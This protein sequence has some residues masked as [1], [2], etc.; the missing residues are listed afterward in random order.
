MADKRVSALDVIRK[1]LPKWWKD[2][3]SDNKE[4]VQMA[5]AVRAGVK[6]QWV[7]EKETGMPGIVSGV[8]GLPSILGADGVFLEAGESYDRNLRDMLEAEGLPR[9]G[10]MPGWMRVAL[11]GGEVL[12][13]APMSA[14]AATALVG[15]VGSSLPKLVAKPV[16]LATE[17]FTPW[18]NPH[19]VNYAAGTIIGGSLRQ[20]EGPTWEAAPEMQEYLKSEHAAFDARAAKRA[21]IEGMIADANDK[22]KDRLYTKYFKDAEVTFAEPIQGFARG[23]LNRL[24]A[25]TIPK[26]LQG[27]QVIKEAGGNWIAGGPESATDMLKVAINDYTPGQFGYATEA[28]HPRNI[29]ATA[30][31]KWLDQKLKSYIRNTMATKEDP[32]RLG[33]EKWQTV[34]KPSLVAKQQARIDKARTSQLA[35]QEAHP[36]MTPEQLIESQD[37]IRQLEGAMNLLAR[38]TGLH[39]EPGFVFDYNLP[40][41]VEG[42]TDLSRDW[43]NAAD[44]SIRSR[45]AGALLADPYSFTYMRSSVEANPWLLKI[46]PETPVY[47][48]RSDI[49]E[50]GFDHLMDELANALNPESGLPANLLIDP[51][52]FEK[53]NIADA[54]A[55]VGE[56]NAWRGAQKAIVDKR[57][58]MNAATVMHKEYPDDPK[59]VRWVEIKLPEPVIAD[60]HMLGPVSGYPEL[61]GIVDRTTGQSVSAGATPE[62]ALR[63]YNLTER[64]SLLKDALKYEGEQLAHCVGGYCPDV[65][66]GKSR[67]FSLRDAEGK[68][69]TTI[70]TNPSFLTPEKREAQLGYAVQRNIG[71]GMSEEEALASA[72]KL[73]PEAYQNISQIRG[74]LNLRPAEEVMPYISDFVKSGK[75]GSVEDLGHTDL[76]PGDTVSDIMPSGLTMSPGLRKEAIDRARESGELPDYLTRDEYEKLLNKFG[77]A[78]E[79]AEGGLATAADYDPSIIDAIL[80]RLHISGEVGSFQDEHTRGTQGGGNIKV[81][82]TPNATVG[83]DVYGYDIKTPIGDFKDI[84]LSGVSF[85]H[86]SGP[87]RIKARKST[88]GKDWGLE[89]QYTFANGGLV[90]SGYNDEYVD[91]LANQLMEEVYG[92]R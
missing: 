39:Y 68:P 36:D 11:A 85:E 21:R 42:T 82:V 54:V 18:I 58:A 17:Y 41:Y 87:H 91:T 70:E 90:N 19:P 29:R 56:I 31:N 10:D 40:R 55:R 16:S 6:A 92:Q 67:I 74:H 13:Q 35:Y 49:D 76:F 80:K 48:L 81:D 63:L 27:T 2:A 43:E 75:W 9:P 61:H 60:E 71:G 45:S 53:M 5:K 12:G 77:G 8:V 59:G 46:P 64:E 57:R 73:Y 47:S 38:N 37:Q 50:A 86:R 4:L 15:K 3:K 72:L 14:K 83:A 88:K 51:T 22:E 66:S 84:G 78:Q 33:V 25:D 79:F 44:A 23:G 28:E 65:T 20:L 62:E 1:E 7:P 69:Y 26:K 24:N 89:Y 32:I 34:D 52:K 30:I